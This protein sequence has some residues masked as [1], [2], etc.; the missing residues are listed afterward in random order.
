MELELDKC[1]RRILK[2]L[3]TNNQITN[4]ELAERVHLSAPTC[5]RRVRRLREAKIIVADVCL[6][7]PDRVGKS[8]N[9][10]IE[11][12]LDRQSE[13]L[14]HAFETKMTKTPEIVQCYMI[15]GKADFMLVAQV[16]N[17]NAYHS[18]VRRVLTS[19]PNV[20]NF[21]SVFALNRSKFQTEIDI[22]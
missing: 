14:Q 3:Q 4:L 1:D 10:F 17:V 6:L 20:R 7:D 21:R 18:F 19:D 5:L 22:S 15:S 16:A 11:V 12:V 2:I 13:V 9:V 8:L